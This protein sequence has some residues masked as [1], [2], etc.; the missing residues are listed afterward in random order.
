[1]IRSVRTERIDD[2]RPLLTI[3]SDL[4]PH[5]SASSTDTR[6]VFVRDGEGLVTAGSAAEIAVPSSPGALRMARETFTALAE[7]AEVEDLVRL[8]G[9]GLMAVGSFAFDPVASASRSV[10]RIPR[11][12]IGSRDGATW[13]TVIDTTVESRPDTGT[14]STAGGPARVAQERAQ[15]SAQERAQEHAPERVSERAQMPDRP[16]YG[17][18]T[19]D[20][21]EWLDVV[22]RAVDAIRAGR[23]EKV[24]LARDVRLWSRAPFP[25]AGVLEALAERFPS[26]FTFRVDGLVGASPELLLRRRGDAVASRVLAGTARRGTDADHD[27][28]L[29]AELLASD[30][31]RREHDLAA[32]SVTEVLRVFCRSVAAPAGPALVRLDNVQHLGSDVTGTLDAPVHILDLLDALHPTAAVAGT[33]R[34]AA[35]TLIRE[36]EGMDRG[37]YAGPVG[38]CDADGDGE[39]AIALR[40]AE[41]DGTRARLF[42]GAGVVDGSLPEAELMETWLKLRA[43]TGVLTGP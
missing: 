41:I 33:P 23:A 7:A 19:L 39:F 4:D 31:D 40:C 32:R 11:T 17:G 5:P 29:G 43:M 6:T 37:R 22:A 26:C 8:P 30:K 36:L 10:L 2:D 13:R 34:E 16:R 1:V 28:R 18:S 21:A 20:D 24:V 14:T 35:L 15:G 42:A 38:W 25:T 12:A 3:L 27:A 9:T